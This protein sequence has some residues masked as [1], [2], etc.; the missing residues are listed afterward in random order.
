MLRELR[1]HDP[2]HYHGPVRRTVSYRSGLFTAQGLRSIST[3]MDLPGLPT[4]LPPSWKNLNHLFIYSP[5]SLGLAHQLLSHCCNL[6]G[7]LLVI[8]WPWSD[9]AFSNNSTTFSSLHLPHL[10]FLSL[11]GLG[12]DSDICTGW[13]FRK[14][15]VP[16]LRTLNYPKYPCIHSNAIPLPPHL[17]V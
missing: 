17:R 4:Q 9:D 1:I 3:D 11:D 7:C 2:M 10:E 12:V 14:I 6:V 16:L 5:I 15:K 13:L 8:R